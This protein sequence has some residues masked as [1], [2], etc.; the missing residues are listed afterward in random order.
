MNF[1]IWILHGAAVLSP[2]LVV[3]ACGYLCGRGAKARKE[4]RNSAQLA[5]WFGRY[6]D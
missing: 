4:R 6:V 3:F 5:S 1:A 2:L